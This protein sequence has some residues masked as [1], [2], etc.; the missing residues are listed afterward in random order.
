MIHQALIA[1]PQDP[2][3]PCALEQRRRRSLAL[4]VT[5]TTAMLAGLAV[6]YALG[7]QQSLQRALARG[8]RDG[9]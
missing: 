3:R 4:V 7:V 8:D 9:V 1:A 5:S 6:G 2:P